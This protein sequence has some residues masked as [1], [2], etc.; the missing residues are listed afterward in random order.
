MRW[1]WMKSLLSSSAL[2]RRAEL[3]CSVKPDPKYVLHNARHDALSNEYFE[4][5]VTMV[6]IRRPAKSGAT[7]PSLRRGCNK[8]QMSTSIHSRRL[9]ET[10]PKCLR[11]NIYCATRR[12]IEKENWFHAD[13]PRGYKFCPDAV[14]RRG[15][16][17]HDVTTAIL[18]FSAN[19]PFLDPTGVIESGRFSGNERKFS[20]SFCAPCQAKKAAGSARVRGK[21]KPATRNR[22]CVLQGTATTAED[23]AI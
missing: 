1:M 2:L 15:E 8:D 20:G 3:G 11:Y 16:C 18:S 4:G 19:L 12:M 7:S 13:L 17:V 9:H 6:H 10:D 5:A 21:P 22:E 14:S 23:S